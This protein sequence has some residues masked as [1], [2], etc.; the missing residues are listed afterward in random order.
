VAC[1]TRKCEFLKN[2]SHQPALRQQKQRISRKINQL[3]PHSFI[4]VL[5]SALSLLF[6]EKGS[7][8]RKL[9]AMMET[10]KMVALSQGHPSHPTEGD[11]FSS[12]EIFPPGFPPF[13][14]ASM[15]LLPIRT[16]ETKARI[17]KDEADFLEREFK[18]NPKPTTQT[19]R[20]FAEDMGVD[21]ARINVS[22]ITLYQS[23]FY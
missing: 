3:L 17:G 4:S 6:E 12:P 18:R 2:S 21:L 16:N 11:Q 13:G 10:P 20:Q 15:L 5:L 8:N 9:P 19:K 1:V 23:H 14:N 22:S 7:V